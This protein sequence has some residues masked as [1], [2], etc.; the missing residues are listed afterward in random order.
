MEHIFVQGFHVFDTGT[1]F[2]SP[3][4]PFLQSLTDVSCKRLSRIGWRLPVVAAWM[5]YAWSNCVWR[6]QVQIRRELSVLER[7]SSFFALDAE[8]A[9]DSDDD[10]NADM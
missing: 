5:L 7:G 3:L 9:N 6:E 10:R 8:E 1:G 4:T 2:K